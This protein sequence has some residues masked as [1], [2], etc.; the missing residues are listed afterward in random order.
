M[1]NPIGKFLYSF[2]GIRQLG[3]K[4]LK[5]K[6]IYQKFYSGIICFNAVE[7]TLFWL[8]DKTCETMDKEIQDKLLELSLQNEVFVDIGANIGIMSLSLALRNP[9]IQVK[10][11]DP[12]KF[13]LKYFKKSVRKNGLER[14]VEI[15]NAAVSDHSGIDFM[16]FAVGPYSGYLSDKGTAV[17]VVDFKSLLSLYRSNKVLFK[18]DIEGFEKNLVSL[19]VKDKN[20]NHCF[21]IEIHPKGLNNI[22]DPDFVLIELLTNGFEITDAYGK[23]VN[24]MSDIED[25]SNVVCRYPAL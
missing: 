17:E 2:K 18:M 10:A 4:V 19:L 24:G 6:T 12:N 16:N 9:S 8:N 20:P 5:N 1:R 13:V 15:I 22:S 21:V 7:F 14:R 3:K 25:W 11:Y 23:P